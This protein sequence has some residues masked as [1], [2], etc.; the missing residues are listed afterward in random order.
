M[1]I[2]WRDMGGAPHE[3]LE[4]ARQRWLRETELPGQPGMHDYTDWPRELL[5]YHIRRNE[6]EKPFLRGGTRVGYR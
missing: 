2:A 4:E 1:S 6:A 5:A 3:E